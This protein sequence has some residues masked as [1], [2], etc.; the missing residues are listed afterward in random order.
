[1]VGVRANPN[2][3]EAQFALGYVNWLLEW[4]WPAAEGRLRLAIGLDPGNGAEHRVLGHILSQ[5]GRHAEA[6]PLMRRAR[7]LEPLEPLSFALSAQVAFQARQYDEATRQ[8]RQAVLVDSAFWIGYVQL[9]QA[10]AQTGPPELA[11]AA[12]VDAARFSGGNSKA[13]SLRGYVLAR[14]GR[15]GEA[16]EVLS[17]LTAAARERY[18]PPTSFALVYAGLGERDGLFEWLEKACDVRDVHLIFLPVDAKWD[19]YRTDPRFQ[20]VLTRCGFGL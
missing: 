3:S 9:A 11:L 17:A 1:M 14:S 6:A 18:V 5:A 7:E 16:R 15:A 19:P 12:L 2:L 8:A 10:Y 4:D 13:L 20:A